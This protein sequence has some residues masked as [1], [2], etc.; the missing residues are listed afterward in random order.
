M[1]PAVVWHAY[2]MCMASF[3]TLCGAGLAYFL[4]RPSSVFGFSDKKCLAKPA[5]PG[6][7]DLK[8]CARTYAASGRARNSASGKYRGGF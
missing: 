1:C 6:F 3:P 2:G 8:E 5:G 4:C 7:A